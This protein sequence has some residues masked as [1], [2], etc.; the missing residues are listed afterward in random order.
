MKLWVTCVSGLYSPYKYSVILKKKN[1]HCHGAEGNGQRVKSEDVCDSHGQ[2]DDH[3]QYA[4]PKIPL[5][6]LSFGIRPM[7]FVSR[8]IVENHLVLRRRM[9]WLQQYSSGRLG[10]VSLPLSVNTYE[11]R[12]C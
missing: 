1:S 4:E 3:G 7:R 8:N 11:E 6:T 12:N 5:A 2:T 10:D 9:N